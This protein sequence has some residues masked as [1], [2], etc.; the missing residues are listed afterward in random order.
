[1]RMQPNELKRYFR[2]PVI[3]LRQFEGVP[4]STYGI[5]MNVFSGGGIVS[6]DIEWYLPEM[7][8]R[9][10]NRT[11]CEVGSAED[12]QAIRGDRT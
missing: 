9:G 7:A 6:L 4:A 5:V 10:G 2:K 12:D 3:L 8:R 1:M 11:V